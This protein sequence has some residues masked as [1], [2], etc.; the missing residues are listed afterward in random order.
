MTAGAFVQLAG[1]V[2][3]GPILAE[4]LIQELGQADAI[5]IFEDCLAEPAGV[6]ALPTPGR[7]APEAAVRGAEGDL[8]AR[9]AHA[10]GDCG[11]DGG[12]GEALEIH[13]RQV[14]REPRAV[15]GEVNVAELFVITQ[16]AAK[17]VEHRRQAAL[18]Q[19]RYSLRREIDRHQW[20]GEANLV[21]PRAGGNGRG[22]AAS[23]FVGRGAGHQAGDGGLLR[24]RLGQERPFEDG[25][26]APL[27]E[28]HGNA[29][30]DRRGCSRRQAQHRHQASPA[31]DVHLHPPVP[32]C[33]SAHIS[34]CSHLDSPAAGH[35]GRHVGPR[36]AGQEQVHV[37]SVHIRIAVQ[38]RVLT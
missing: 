33:L 36:E 12:R 24:G 8:L 18:V 13:R 22:H 21:D 2:N 4:I 25:Q 3:G 23:R 16:R 29:L 14:T 17:L 20:S 31:A 27:E 10:R 5:G 19:S 34:Q 26:F 1:H 6:A 30:T 11:A 9:Q 28:P 15:A 37:S 32:R 38:Q 7:A 35:L